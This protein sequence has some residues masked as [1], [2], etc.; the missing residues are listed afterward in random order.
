M[1]N[2]GLFP[3]ERWF[4]GLI[5]IFTLYITYGVTSELIELILPNAYDEMSFATAQGAQN[6]EFTKNN[7]VISVVLLLGGIMFYLIM[8]GVPYQ[9]EDR[10]G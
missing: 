9:R 10:I 6:I 3:I 7:F 5:L 2:K 8:A 1:N 4:A